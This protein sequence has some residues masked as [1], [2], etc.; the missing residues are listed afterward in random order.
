[1]KEQD[2][3]KRH[4]LKRDSTPM[5]HEALQIVRRIKQEKAQ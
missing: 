1:M 4:R 2:D 3:K 5:D